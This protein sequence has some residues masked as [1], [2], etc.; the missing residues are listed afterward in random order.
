MGRRWTTVAVILVSLLV[1][2]VGLS[3]VVEGLR[4]VPSTPTRLGWAPEIPIRYVN[5]DGVN[6][7][8]IKVGQ[9]P[10]RIEQR[11]RNSH[12]AGLAKAI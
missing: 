9:E 12:S 10:P 7:R 2:P 6:L 8:Y 1:V 11:S 3:Y 4:S 5:V